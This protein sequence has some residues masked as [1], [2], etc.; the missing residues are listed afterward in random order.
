[1]T[2]ADFLSRSGRRCC[3][4]DEKDCE[5]VDGKQREATRVRMADKQNRHAP[6]IPA[7]EKSAENSKIR[8]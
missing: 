4:D 5:G 7:R 6:L 1:L 2:L 8:L 3:H